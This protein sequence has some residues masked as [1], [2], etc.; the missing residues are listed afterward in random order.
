M[1]RGY[2]GNGR[3]QRA[4]DKDAYRK[5]I[6][7]LERQVRFLEYDA[8]L[9]KD[10]L[11]QDYG[12]IEIQPFDAWT[13]SEVSAGFVGGRGADAIISA[14]EV[15]PLVGQTPLGPQ[16]TGGPGELLAGGFAGILRGVGSGV[17]ATT[18]GNVAK[19]EAASFARPQVVAVA[20]RTPV[21][22]KVTSWAAAGIKADLN[23]GRWVQLGGPNLWNFAKT[24]LWGG[25]FNLN[26]R[27]PFVSWKPSN[28]PFTNYVSDFVEQSRLM[29]PEGWEFIKGLLGQRIIK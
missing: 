15:L 23:P 9:F 25:K 2:T 24:G 8:Q 11:N 26:W 13:P 28:V 19:N 21:T 3:N 5:Q 12:D 22:V 16:S 10:R 18:A 14:A 6:S 4:I 17:A 7:D 20:A 27:Y 1:D 29:W